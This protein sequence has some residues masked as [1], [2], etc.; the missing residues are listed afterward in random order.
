MFGAAMSMGGQTQV[1]D[2]TFSNP[3]C[4]EHM[5]VKDAQCCGLMGGQGNRYPF[6]SSNN[7]MLT[8]GFNL[9]DHQDKIPSYS[10]PVRRLLHACALAPPLHRRPS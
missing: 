9:T 4:T 7:T 8:P 6:I 5:G 1:H 10:H 2:C 3:R